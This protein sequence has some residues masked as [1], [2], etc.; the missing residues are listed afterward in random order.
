MKATAARLLLVGAL[1]L[2][3]FV[4]SDGDAFSTDFAGHRHHRMRR[5]G[6]WWM[7][8]IGRHCLRLAHL[9]HIHNAEAAVPTACEHLV[10]EAQRV[11]QTVALAG[12]SRLFTRSNILSSQP[13]A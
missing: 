12:P 7:V 10:A 4:D 1:R 11:V 9:G 5:L 2:I 3:L 8:I 6:K 13:P